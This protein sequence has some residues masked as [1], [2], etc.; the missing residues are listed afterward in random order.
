MVLA[1]TKVP[2]IIQLGPVFV[3]PD[4]L[5]QPVTLRVLEVWIIK[6]W[7]TDVIISETPGNIMNLKNNSARL[8]FQAMDDFTSL[9]I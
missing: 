6:L 1:Q 3:I 8:C 4:F 2:V 5:D 9:Q 7:R